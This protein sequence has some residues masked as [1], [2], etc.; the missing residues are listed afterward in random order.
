MRR[1]AFLTAALF[2]MAASWLRADNQTQ[3]VQQALKD[4]GFYY[5]TVDGQPG[6]ETDAAVKRYQIRQGLDVT[7]K[8]DEQTLN[9]LNLGNGNAANKPTVE[10]VQ[11]PSD[12]DA[13][14]PAPRRSFTRQDTQQDKDFLQSHPAAPAAPRDDDNTPANPAQPSQPAPPP[15]PPP[16]DSADEPATAPADYSRFF[17]KTPYETAP[18]VVQRD[19]VLRAKP[20]LAR[21]GFYRGV[22]DSQVD[23]RFSR[24]LTAYQRDADLSATGRLDMAT[25]SDMN[26]LP[27]R[28]VV[29]RPPGPPV[30]PY[31]YDEPRDVYRGIWVH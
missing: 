7:G 11:P 14:T 12:Q 31:P 16:A 9:S 24:A 10:A 27:Q 25:L 13:A 23:D 20:R 5:G 17:R 26:L 19:T 29:I 28:H 15:Q 22:V 6:P 1:T 4:Q 2:C 18:L 8:L 21:E 30:A 3:S